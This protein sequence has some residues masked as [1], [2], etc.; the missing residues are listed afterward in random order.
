MSTD[1]SSDGLLAFLREATLAGRITPS[2]AKS[3]RAAAQTLFAKL[4]DSEAADLRTLD[5]DALKSRFLDTQGG[6]LRA[7]V[8]DLYAERLGWALD[9]YFR[10][11]ES[12]NQFVSSST[13]VSQDTARP[14]AQLAPKT[15]EERALEAVRLTAPRQRSD[16]IPI[17]L[18][19][20]RVVYLH[21]LPVDLTPQEARKIA[22][23]V[24]A[25]ANEAEDAQ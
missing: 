9:D 20:E 12:P 8:V 14:K 16:V 2:A 5:I 25:L 13:T 6:G 21:S 17:P 19:A 3:R 11:V 4:S 18:G 22:R 23:V 10:F 15:P 1:Y 7:E 24:E